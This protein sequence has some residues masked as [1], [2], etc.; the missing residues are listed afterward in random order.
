MIFVIVYGSIGILHC[1]WFALFMLKLPDEALEE[2]EWD[3][4]KESSLR[5]ICFWIGCELALLI[6]WLPIE[7]LKVAECIIYLKRL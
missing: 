2:E 3:Y 7:I 1:I 5:E 4:L 6:F